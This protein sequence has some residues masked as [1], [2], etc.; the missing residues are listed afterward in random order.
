M[1][2]NFALQ[3]TAVVI[4]VLAAL[5]WIVIKAVKIRKV[6]HSGCGSCSI[7]DACNLKELKQKQ[8]HDECKKSSCC[9]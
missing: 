7:A 6:K 2:T 1:S 5:I 4:I 8:T 3:Y 9:H